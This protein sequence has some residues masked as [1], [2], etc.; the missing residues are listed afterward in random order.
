M[1]AK[2]VISYYIHPEIQKKLV[3][4]QN[5]VGLN[6]SPMDFNKGNSFVIFLSFRFLV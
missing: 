1:D 3:Q 5:G 4:M 2:A 6:R